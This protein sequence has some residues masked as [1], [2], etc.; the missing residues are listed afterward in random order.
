[1]GKPFEEGKGDE[2]EG[3][4]ARAEGV[5]RAPQAKKILSF[6]RIAANAPSHRSRSAAPSALHRVTSDNVIA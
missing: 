4:G 2:G 3:E 6:A 5:V 1:M